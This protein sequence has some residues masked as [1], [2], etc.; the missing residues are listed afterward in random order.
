MGCAVLRWG[1]LLPGSTVIATTRFPVGAI[2]L[3][4]CY[5]SCGRERVMLCL[6]SRG[7]QLFVLADTVQCARLSERVL[8]EAPYYVVRHVRC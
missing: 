4:L 8:C 1:P 7:N 2:G 3:R 5:A 6:R